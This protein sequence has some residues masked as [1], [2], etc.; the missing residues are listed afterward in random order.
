[1]NPYIK[2]YNNKSIE[3]LLISNI[4]DFNKTQSIS[5]FDFKV[6]HN[7]IRSVYKN[8]D[9]LSVLLHQFN[10]NFEVI[11]LTETFQ[12]QDT[13]IFNINGYNV[14]YN[15]GNL[16][17]NDG[18][19]VYLKSNIEYSY[20][21]INISE[22]KVLKIKIIND[23]KIIIITAAYRSPSTCLKSFNIGLL[24]YLS[25]IEKNDMHIIVGDININILS[26][27][28]YVEEYK[29]ILNSF[30]YISYI[31]DYTRMQSKTCL[32]HFF[33][34][35]ELHKEEND[36]KSFILQQN[37]TDH[38]PTIVSFKLETG[39]SKKSAINNNNVKKCINY[40]RLKKDLQ[41]ENWYELYE[42]NNIDLITDTFIKKLTSYIERST[43]L[44]KTNCKHKKRKEWITLG[45]IKSINTK[46]TM[47][48]QLLSEPNNRELEKE[49]KT[50][51]HKLSTLIKKTKVDYY[52]TLINKNKNSSKN[53]WVTVNNICNKTKPKSTINKIQLEDGCIITEKSCIANRMN[54]HYSSLGERYANKIK[55]PN[56]FNDNIKILENTMYL[57]PT[58][59]L[60]I[61]KVIEKLKSKKT[62]GHDNIRSETLKL[63]SNEIAVPLTYITNKCFDTG[64][65]PKSLKI[66]IIKP[67]HKGGDYLRVVNYRP[68]SLISNIAKIIERIL[69]CRI[70][71]FLN[72]HKL[73]SDRQYGFREGKSTEDAI[74]YLTTQIYNSLDKKIPT[75]CIFVDLAKAFD[76]VCHQKLLNKLEHYGLRGNVLN[77]LK[78]YLLDRKQYV[79]LG[80]TVSDPKTVK[81]GV[82]QGTVL[83]PI[84]F[85]IYINS[86]L[87]LKTTGTILS[88]A[89]DTAILY[90]ANSWQE[91]KEMTENDFKN[92]KSWFQGNTLTLNCNKT[93]Y[94]P[95]TSYVNNLPNFGPLIIDQ[96]TSIP[97]A[98]SI[99]YLGIIIDRHLRW[100]LQTKN[101]IKK[102]RGLLPRFKYLKDILDIKHLKVLY[103]AL[104]QSQISYGILGWGGVNDHY[105][106]N[107]NVLQ[108]WVIKIIL[109]KP[110]RYS[111]DSLFTEA[112]ILDIRQ[113]F[114]LN[115]LLNV[116]QNKSNIQTITHN[117]ETRHKQSSCQRPR[118]EKTVGQR[119]YLYLSP[120]IYD[121][122]PERIKNIATLGLFKKKVKQWITQTPRCAFHD[123]VNQNINV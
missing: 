112:G 45:L 123:L 75:L 73:L 42:Q 72:K 33:I 32:D 109:G 81:Y 92:I 16:N 9:E 4:N 39:K 115:V 37:V 74:C 18:V 38:F 102:V 44:V 88:F 22:I 1:M 117:Y 51:K 77:L 80:E 108:K 103:Y 69:K 43:Y 93:F 35:S 61:K 15:E 27:T 104:V 87:L 26:D 79:D 106:E 13:S 36:I 19:I 46:N 20:E 24:N 120:R 6:F 116:F 2:E 78:S 113:L 53:L 82:P 8:Y 55:V 23:N 122:L 11:V 57:Y 58:D 101:I 121:I 30:G 71:N 64:C 41:D 91:L 60:E 118:S 66:G 40:K 10:E 3:T 67:I 96:D 89:D 63:I 98:T 111:S 76:T 25:E 97:E 34:K 119:N 21:I 12:I 65:F 99:K 110:L 107:L 47:Y 31:N 62:P 94:L 52:K 83:G 5:Q 114:C 90:K 70:V 56:N 7:N 95:F 59:E 29:N 105:L 84:L 14:I 54:E 86:L 100:D 48:Q 85:T 49:Y 17:K 68:I 50:Y 28:D